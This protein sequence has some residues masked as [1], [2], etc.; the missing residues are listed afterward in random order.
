[1]CELDA[2]H[3]A[4]RG[5]GLRAERWRLEQHAEQPRAARNHLARRG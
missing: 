1:V 4:R 5:R 2:R 3:G